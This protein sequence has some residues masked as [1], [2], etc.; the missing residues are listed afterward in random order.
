MAERDPLA[1]TEEEDPASKI[2]PINCKE[3]D[4]LH[5]HIRAIENDCHIVPQ[6]SMKLTS[7][8]EVA[9]NEAF[10]GLTADEAYKIEYYS[11]FRHVQDPQKRDGLEA[12]DAIFLRNFLDDVH[13]DQPKGCWT[14]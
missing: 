8:H 10:Q 14:I 12:D 3:V 11:H 2:I 1:S 5:Y 4:R 13:G 6:G 9:R 7:A